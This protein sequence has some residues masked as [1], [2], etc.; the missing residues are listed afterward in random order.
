M[1]QLDLVASNAVL[2][3]RRFPADL[4]A[5]VARA[6]FEIAR[7]D[8]DGFRPLDRAVAGTRLAAKADRNLPWDRRVS[9]AI[10]LMPRLNKLIWRANRCGAA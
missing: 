5:L 1:G 4:G 3:L 7:G 9:L 8:T 6:Q 2:G 10:V